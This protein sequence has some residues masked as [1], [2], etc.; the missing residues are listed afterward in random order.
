MNNF[1]PQVHQ[2]RNNAA[3]TYRMEDWAFTLGARY[4]DRSFGTIDNSDPVSQ[5][6]QGFGSY[7]VA[8]A[9]IR[10]TVNQNWNL[11]R[12]GQFE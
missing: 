7:L 4:S 10:Y 8:D 3:A 12:R 11:S 5:T 2:A 6:Y 9:R 1:L